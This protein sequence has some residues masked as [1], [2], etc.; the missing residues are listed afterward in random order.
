MGVQDVLALMIVLAA[1]A[2]AG[3]KVFGSGGGSCGG[4]A[5]S[6]EK[7]ATTPG[8]LKPTPLLTPDQVGKPYAS[9]DDS[10]A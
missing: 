9:D 4:C 8:D 10:G 7:T 2:Y 6:R 1:A 3:R 5:Q